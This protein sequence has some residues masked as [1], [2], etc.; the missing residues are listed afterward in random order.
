MWVRVRVW[1]WVRVRVWV[2]VWVWVWVRVRVRVRVRVCTCTG[3][4]GR[5]R[6]REGERRRHRCAQAAA[7]I[8]ATSAVSVSLVR[9]CSA[10]KMTSARKDDITLTS[11]LAHPPFHTLPHPNAAMNPETRCHVW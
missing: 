3:K 10:R 6:E 5:E 9:A 11:L 8:V 4:R 7:D 2:W 1:V